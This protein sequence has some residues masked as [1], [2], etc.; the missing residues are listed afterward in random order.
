MDVWDLYY[1]QNE[2]AYSHKVSDA[3]LTC[4]KINVNLSTGTHHSTVPTGKWVGIGD[5]DG[6][7]KK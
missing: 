2:I 6:I 7:L 1:R 5:Q 3:P 4:L